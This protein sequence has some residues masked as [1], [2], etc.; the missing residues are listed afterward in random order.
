M[1]AIARRDDQL[2]LRFDDP[3]AQ[4]PPQPEQRERPDPP[5]AAKRHD[6]HAVLVHHAAATGD[7]LDLVIARER[8]RQGESIARDARRRQVEDEDG[9]AG[10]RRHDA[11]PI[12]QPAVPAQALRL[13]ADRNSG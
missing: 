5:T 3:R 12:G 1:A 9:D 6:G 10:T 13:H 2:R 8:I 11:C 7:Q 4:P